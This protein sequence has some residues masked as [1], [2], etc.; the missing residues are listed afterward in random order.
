MMKKKILSN[1]PD[2]S[3]IFEIGFWNSASRHSKMISWEY[4]YNRIMKEEK[5]RRYHINRGD[6]CAI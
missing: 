3:R 1:R 5:K 6:I 2:Y 4:R